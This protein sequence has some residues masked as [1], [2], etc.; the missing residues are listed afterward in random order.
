MAGQAFRPAEFPLVGRDVAWKVEGVNRAGGIILF[1]ED[2]FPRTA[3]G[4]PVAV[5]DFKSCTGKDGK[6]VG[7]GLAV[8]DM[9]AHVFALDVLTPEAADLTDAK[10]G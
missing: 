7:T 10:T 5:E 2:P 8:R 3:A 9:D 1:R 6:S 4:K